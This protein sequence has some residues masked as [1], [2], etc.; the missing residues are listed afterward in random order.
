MQVRS[1]KSTTVRSAA[2]ALARAALRALER[3]SP[4]LASRFAA[5]LFATPP[6]RRAP[7]EWERSI[8]SEAEA[9][10]LRAAGTH[11]RGARLGHGPAVLLVH[12]W[13]GGGSQLAA[14][15]PPLLAAGC[16]VVAFDG[17]AHGA[18]AGKT[19]T[20]PEFA[21]ATAEVAR[22]F[23]ARA[24]IAHSLG[25][26]AVALALH[27]GLPL[28]AAVLVAP[29]RAATAIFDG[30]CAAMGLGEVTRNRTRDRLEQRVGARIADLDLPALVAGL[31]TP[32]LVIHD[33]GDKEI[34][35]E[36]GATIAAAWP[37]ARLLSTA[38]LGHRR[39]LRDQNVI[40][41]AGAFVLGRLPRCGCG[42]LPS[43]VARGEP[44]CETC[45]LE[46]HLADREARAAQVY[47]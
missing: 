39:I 2:P 20:M 11:L 25:A 10:Q 38:G 24:A 21:D 43:A 28:D 37:G 14:F 4:R 8:L 26:T 46:L 23:G 22:R 12:G 9:F 15:V 45:L 30:F 7:R 27:R 13:G 5:R 19:A 40:D 31:R 34:P 3:M 42:R 33:T 6:G 41:E 29:P 16:S 47:A 35:F 32:A 17:P 44:R 18:S 1:D 36:D